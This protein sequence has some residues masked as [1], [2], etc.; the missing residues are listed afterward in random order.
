M[1]H[2]SGV[3]RPAGDRARTASRR[4]PANRRSHPTAVS[5]LQQGRHA[6]ADLRIQQGSERRDLRDHPA[7]PDHRA[8]ADGVV[9]RPGRIGRAA[10]PS[11]DGKSLAFVR[12]VRLQSSPV[13]PRSR[14]RA[15]TPVFDRSRQGPAG[16]VGDP[17]C[18]SAV[19]V[20]AGRQGDR[21]SGARARSGAS[22]S[23]AKQGTAGAVHRAG[24]ADGERGACAFRRRSTRR[25]SRC[26]MLRDVRDVARRQEVAYSA[27]GQICTSRPLPD[28]SP[29]RLTARRDA[30]RALR[31]R[32]SWSR[33][34]AVDRLHDVDRRD[35]GRVRDRAC[36][37][38]RG[39][40]DVVTT[41]GHY[42]EP[43]FSPDGKWIVYRK[44][45]RPTASAGDSTAASPASTSCRSTARRPPRLVREGGTQPQFD[46]TGKRDL[47]PRSR[48]EKAVLVS[49]GRRR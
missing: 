33:R 47:P 16:S 12:R 23:P 4:T 45:R 18:L 10:R 27:L 14:D 29:K 44:R 46:H 13:R 35:Y 42:T 37:T 8:R 22:T 5:L 39:G 34:R 25:S 11:P 19:R 7:R 26:K 6:G 9:G 28:G 36:R 21:R 32:P 3:R 30:A 2:V 48:D 49:V 24:R 31:V 17:R 15:R 43:A 38:A 40:R 20:D 1:F 41:P